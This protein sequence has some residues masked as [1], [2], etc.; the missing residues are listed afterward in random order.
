ME[1]ERPLRWDLALRSCVD[2][3]AAIVVISCPLNSVACARRENA[4]SN[5]P[6]FTVSGARR[7]PDNGYHAYLEMA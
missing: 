2:G 1:W 4:I 5:R 7:H 3:I 6:K